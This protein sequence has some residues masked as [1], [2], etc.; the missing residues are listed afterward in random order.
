LMDQ[1][2]EK[3]IDPLDK[4]IQEARAIFKD[5]NKKWKEG[6]LQKMKKKYEEIQDSYTYLLTLHS[7]IYRLIRQHEGL[8]SKL[9]DLYA[10]WYLDIS[11]D[12]KQST[13]MMQTQADILQGI[14]TD[15]YNLLEPIIKND[16][17]AP[18]NN[19]KLS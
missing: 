18:K 8:V 19:E 11:N 1:F 7:Y 17:K 16:L 4:R 9:C 3:H 14:F 12:G 6:E 10:T 5:T 13:E 15:L 2:K